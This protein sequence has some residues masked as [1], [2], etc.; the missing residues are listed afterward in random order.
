MNYDQ[1]ILNKEKDIDEVGY[2]ISTNPARNAPMI[3]VEDSQCYAKKRI[4]DRDGTSTF[5]YYIKTKTV[6]NKLCNPW[7]PTDM[8]NNAKLSSALNRDPYK[9]TEVT[10][11]GFELYLLFLKGRST[12][13]LDQVE[14]ERI[15][16]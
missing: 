6:D 3:D 15:N 7:N 8:D 13:I 4:F 12:A 1:F 14:R 10:I 11:N 9:F 5:K 16:G 2:T